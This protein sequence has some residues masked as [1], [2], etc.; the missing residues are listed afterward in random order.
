MA[1]VSVEQWANAVLKGLGIKANPENRRAMVGWARAEGGHWNNDAKYNPLNTT[2]PMPGAGNT[3]TQGNIKV[4][5]SWQQG[6]KATVKTLKNGYYGPILAALKG[7]SA[8]DVAAAIGKTP[9]GTGGGLVQRTIAGTPQI[10]NG[11]TGKLPG[12]K[13][14][15]TANAFRTKTTTTP[16]VDNS[17]LRQSLKID[18][19]NNRGN[20]DALL[21]LGLG[22]R[23]AQDTPGT[24]TTRIAGG[25]P[26]AAGPA[27]QGGPQAALRW[28][29]SKIGKSEV[30]GNNR[31]PLP[32][33]LNAKFGFGSQG[34]Q[35]WCAMFTSVAVTRGGA[36]KE[37]RS[38]SVGE[39]RSK[40]EQGIGYKGFVDPAKAKR[41][42]L[43][44]FG[45][46]HIGMVQ[47]VTPQGIKMVAGNDSNKVQSRVV[48]IGSGD[49][50]R[51]KY[52]A[53]K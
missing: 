43:I 31:G 49:I 35:P 48:P 1:D 29:D 8:E 34:A 12:A 39:I 5:R 37:A 26:A 46:D 41:G 25:G 51:P 52:G 17:P 40:A 45:N 3:G 18:Y 15:G 19:L 50:V 14:A 11:S 38:A 4:Y 2:Q 9:W 22:L 53:R 16:G 20:P 23:Q 30:G 44:L 24:T 33:K 10:T 13:N 32:D 21:A 27:Q 7:G 36:P 6:V 47:K 42:D 28:A